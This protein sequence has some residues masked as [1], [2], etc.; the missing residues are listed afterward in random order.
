MVVC[1]CAIDWDRGLPEPLFWFLQVLF[2]VL[3]GV[4]DSGEARNRCF[5]GSL[6]VCILFLHQQ[7]LWAAEGRAWELPSAI[8]RKYMAA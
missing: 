8:L 4:T 7:W 1:V 5:G 3:K 2:Q 6:G